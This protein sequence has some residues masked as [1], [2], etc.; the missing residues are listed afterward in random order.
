MSGDTIIQL[1][2]SVI[3]QDDITILD[4][5]NIEINRGEFV[6]LIGRTGSGK[7]SL[8]KTLYGELKLKTGEGKIVNYNLKGIKSKK[9]SELRRTIGIVFQ[10]F[11]LLMDRSVKENLIFVMKSTGWKNKAKMNEKVDELLNRVGIEGKH[12]KF[13]GQLSGGEQQRVAIARALINDPELILADEP[14]GNLDPITSDEI[15]KLLFEIS[16][17][18]KAIL[19]ATHDYHIINKFPSRTLKTEDGAI[20]EINLAQAEE[21]RF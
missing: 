15:M 10:D 14:T 1:I 20:S 5:V 19:M 6:Y 9:I 3:K 4:Q 16:S 21:F 2:N 18:G 11:Q 13:P 8:L 12:H 17:T 7:S